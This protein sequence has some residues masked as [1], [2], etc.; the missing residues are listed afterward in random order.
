MRPVTYELVHQDAQTGA[1]AGLLHTP[2]GEVKTPVFM[3]V[4]T[5]AT[6]KAMTPEELK[7]IGAEIILANTYH[8]FLRPGS[9]LIAKAGGLHRFMHWDGPILTDSGGFQ[10]FSLASAQDIEEE[11]VTFRSHFDGSKQFLSP[12]TSL[13]VQTDLGSD[14][15][16]AFDECVPYPASYDYT[17]RSMER[18][19]RWLDR[20]MAARKREDQALFAIVQ[21]GFY[22]DLRV[23][24]AQASVERD[25]DGYAIGGISVGEPRE[26]FLRILDFTTPLLPADKPRYNMG[27]GTPDYLFASVQ[28]GID[29]C[30]CVLPTR[31]A[32]HGLAMTHD[33]KLNVRNLRFREDFGP[34]DPDCDCYVCQNY[35]RAYIRHLNNMNEILGARL[36]SYHNLYFLTQMMEGMRQAILED[37]FLDFQEKFMERY[38]ANMVD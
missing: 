14:I 22:E 28:A 29:M 3:P 8:L 21:G 38:R 10:V 5:Q 12:E 1:R 15:M 7:R 37:R 2:H 13:A 4:G 6:V 34:L 30:D 35:S 24:S 26:D 31:V 16:M 17:A 18:T 11:G 23:M 32:R 9:D 19:L 36:L 25:L 33:G 20:S 27:I